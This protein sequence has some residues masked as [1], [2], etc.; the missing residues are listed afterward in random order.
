MP[1]HFTFYRRYKF[2]SHV[3][4]RQLGM[5]SDPKVLAT[6]GGYVWISECCGKK[7]VSVYS[8][9]IFGSTPI[10]KVPPTSVLKLIY[11]WACQTSVSN[12]ESWV[13]VSRCVIHNGIFFC[14]HKY[15][16][17]NSGYLFPKENY[18]SSSKYI[19]WL[20]GADCKYSLPFHNFIWFLSEKC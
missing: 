1:E 5:F 11:H 14:T 4:L 12:V 10:D 3:F 6:S 15:T 20:Y 2:S 16:K 19:S 13:K 7:Y 8:G 9:S 18:T 17:H